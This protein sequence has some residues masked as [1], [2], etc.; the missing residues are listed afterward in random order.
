VSYVPSTRTARFIATEPFGAGEHVT[1]VLPF[2][3]R[4]WSFTVNA[5]A[6]AVDF[7]EPS[8]YATGS[9]PMR[10]TTGDLDGDGDVDLCAAQGASP[11]LQIFLNDGKGTLTRDTVIVEAV[12]GDV[13]AADLDADGDL[14]LVA[15]HANGGRAV[16]LINGG[17]GLFESRTEYTMDGIRSV[18]VA[19]LDGNGGLD[20]GTE[21]GTA[22]Q[23]TLLMNDG[24]GLLRPG[25]SP[26]LIHPPDL[27]APFDV[28]GDGDLD[29]L[30]ADAIGDL[31]LFTNDGTGVFSQATVYAAGGRVQSLR[32][33]DIDLDGD[34]DLAVSRL[35]GGFSVL[36]NDGLGRFVV[37][38]DYPL[39]ANVRSVIAADLDADGQPDLITANGDQATVSVFRNAGGGRLA[40]PSDFATGDTV[41]TVV[42]ADLDHDGDLDLAT[43]G[44][45]SLALF[46]NAEV[47]AA[48]DTDITDLPTL[49][50][51]FALGQNFPNPFNPTTNI[52]F[53]LPQAAHVRLEIIN[54]LGQRVALLVNTM[55]QPGV[56]TRTW[57]GLSQDGKAL[58]SGLYLYRLQAGSFTQVNK[59][60]LLK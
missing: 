4:V 48:N 22:A 58:P 9:P 12:P 52:S 56:Y 37:D 21:C 44:E 50:G 38:S 33:T 46:F 19:D 59:M 20:L 7:P 35:S 26:L 40:P 49:P 1:V 24:R 3:G 14:D 53:A 45:H 2:Y 17:G 5:H 47:S 36:H 32:A 39:T 60:L 18:F 15:T 28:D 25:A 11:C 57:R 27:V 29:L 8:V 54:V 51:A 43:G 10:L 41:W 30:A 34:L 55:L 23:I 31:L 16:A 13:R 42:A 6:A